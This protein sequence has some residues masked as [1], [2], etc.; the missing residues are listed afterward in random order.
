MKKSEHNSWGAKA[1][2]RG[3]NEKGCGNRNVLQWKVSVSRSKYKDR[4]SPKD[5]ESQ[6]EIAC[7]DLKSEEVIKDIYF[8][9]RDKQVKICKSKFEP[10][11]I[12][13]IKSW[14]YSWFNKLEPEVVFY[15]CKKDVEKLSNVNLYKDIFEDNGRTVHVIFST[16]QCCQFVRKHSPVLVHCA[17]EVTDN[18]VVN[19]DVRV[20]AFDFEDSS[21]VAR[22]STTFVGF[23]L[24][25]QF[26]GYNI[27]DSREFFERFYKKLVQGVPPQNAYDKTVSYIQFTPVKFVPVTESSDFPVFSAI[28][29]GERKYV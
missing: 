19:T 14:L 6:F 22:S 17:S 11:I 2:R 23:S 15:V 3:A 20:S 25:Y 16:V 8:G 21:S 28:K 5:T 29:N 10:T 27:K 18:I 13:K 24:G 9:E 26:G 7:D 12:D 1:R 4:L